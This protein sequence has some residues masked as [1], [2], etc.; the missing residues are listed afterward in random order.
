[1]A[2][3]DQVRWRDGSVVPPSGSSVH[4]LLL[5]NLAYWGRRL[6][7]ISALARDKLESFGRGSAR[8]GELAQMK[9]GDIA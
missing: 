7:E 5:S 2:E 9:R 6:I 3:V 4:A 1:M 8:S